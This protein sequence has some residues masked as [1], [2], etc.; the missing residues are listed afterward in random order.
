MFPSERGS[1]HEGELENGLGEWARA[2]D[3]NTRSEKSTV[4]VSES[5]MNNAPTSSL[6]MLSAL[7]GAYTQ[8]FLAAASS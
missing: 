1:S 2:E 5:D 7:G 3:A 6:C 8:T 4:E